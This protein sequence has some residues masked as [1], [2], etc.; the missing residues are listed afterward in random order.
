MGVTGGDG[1]LD[2]DV[3]QALYER[4]I[5]LERVAMES[6]THGVELAVGIW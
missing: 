2:P 4:Y 6:S 1:D 5:E 3:D